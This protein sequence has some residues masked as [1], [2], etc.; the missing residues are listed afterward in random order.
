MFWSI[1]DSFVISHGKRVT[2]Y[3]YVTVKVTVDATGCCNKVV[4]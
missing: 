2:L 1:G 3:G 4:F